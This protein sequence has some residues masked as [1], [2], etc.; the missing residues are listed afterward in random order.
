MGTK[1]F[2]GYISRYYSGPRKTGKE[3]IPDEAKEADA[4]SEACTRLHATLMNKNM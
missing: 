2:S 1:L 3:I 4:G